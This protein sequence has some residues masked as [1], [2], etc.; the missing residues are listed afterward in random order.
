MKIS[1]V[2]PVYNVE[3]Y[4][5]R[6]LDSVL[7]S[8]SRLIS[9]DSRNS[10][11][12][13]CVNDGSTDGSADILEYY[14]SEIHSDGVTFFVLSQAHCGPGPA[15]NIAL[16]VMSGDYVMFVDSD[17]WIVGDALVAFAQVAEAS[18]AQLVVS[19][20]FLKDSDRVAVERERAR[21]GCFRWRMRK[22]EWVFGKK[23]QYCVW[24]KLYRVGLFRTRRFPAT[25]F[26]DMPV[27]TGI[28]GELQEIAVMDEPFYVYCANAGANSLV[29]SEFS[30]RKMRDSLAVVRMMLDQ[31]SDKR[32]FSFAV[33]QAV[34]G[35]SSTVGQVYKS[36]DPELMAKFLA[37]HDELMM[38][39]PK[40]ARR[41]RMKARFRLWRLVRAG[42]GRHVVSRF[43]GI[44]VDP[45]ELSDVIAKSL[46]IRY[47]LT[48]VTVRSTCPVFRGE[49]VGVA[50]V[51]VKLDYFEEWRRT[52][53][54]L[55][56]FRG[57]PLFSPMLFDGYIDYHGRAVSVFEWRDAVIVRPENMTENQVTGFLQ[58]CRELAAVFRGVKDGENL[59]VKPVDP[60]ALYEVVRD[61][62]GRR[63]Y[64]SFLLAELLSIPVALRTYG[65]RELTIIH[66][67]FHSRNFRFDGDRMSHVFDFGLVSRGLGCMDMANAFLERYSCLSLSREARDRLNK[68][69]SLMLAGSPWPREELTIACNIVR[70]QFAARRI[71]KHPDSAWVAFDVWRRDRALREFLSC[72]ESR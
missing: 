25:I 7:F 38:R 23:I 34:D 41:L 4:L 8:A 44:V 17:D 62:V 14:R 69:T 40:L 33:H 59:C 39:Y 37:A 55:K 65:N 30:E 18:D 61:Y 51:C 53:G 2:I 48:A 64:L 71:R 22:S 35:H 57:H 27:M 45:V 9:G 60:V 49:A 43:L 6:C 67:D 42:V 1:V 26:E 24:N 32:A 11:E 21:G 52:A 29:R 70:L 28:F 54:L 10:V 12:I 16:D 15:R 58:G 56:Q 5:K 47:K 3:R 46:G 66:G 72:L 68:V 63:P 31:A 20:T 13:I 50:P 19:G 36:R